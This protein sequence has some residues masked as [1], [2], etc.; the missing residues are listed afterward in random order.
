MRAWIL[1][2]LITLTGCGSDDDD[3]SQTT[4]GN[5]DA[6]A[7]TGVSKGPWSLHVDET[8]ALVRWEACRD[9]TSAALVFAPEGGAAE[10][11]VTATVASV[12]I[13]NTYEAAFVLDRAPDFAGTYYMHEAA[14]T[15]LTAGTC[16][17]YHLA[18]D[19]ERKGRV[20]T[21]KP[22]GTPFKLIAVGDTNPGLGSTQTLLAKIAP[23]NYDLTLHEG[24]VQYYASGLE[25]W[26]YWFGEMAP[27]LG[28]GQFLPAPGNHE[29]EKDDEFDKY[30]LRFFGNAGWSGKD[31]YQSAHSGGV[32]FFSLNTELPVDPGTEQGDWLESELMTA[33][34]QPGFRFSIVYFHRPFLTCGDTSQDDSGFNAFSP[35]FEQYK[36]LLVLQ[37]H[38]HG[39]E[40]FEV[41]LSTDATKTITYLTVAGGGGSLGDVDAGI[42]RPTC[43]MRVSSGAFYHMAVID[44]GAT[45]LSGRIIDVDGAERDTF[46]KPID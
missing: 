26:Q 4:P 27:M 39:Y 30:F 2:A 35:I 6:G 17:A 14:L 13:P 10:T 11:T 32:Y 20:C 9:G 21:S 40:R 44:V 22:S 15:G 43:S 41:P 33:S 25:T 16:Y 1:L 24:D 23:E 42:D 7:C 12:D 36:V 45:T 3:T 8:S 28:Q 19:P 5:Q 18:A 38:M 46:S 29:Y 34:Q 37:G 31:G